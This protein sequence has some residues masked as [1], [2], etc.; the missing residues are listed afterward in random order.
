MHEHPK[1]LI[2]RQVCYMLCF[3]GDMNKCLVTQNRE[4]TIVQ[5]ADATRVKLSDLVNLLD[6]TWRSGD[7]GLLMGVDCI[8]AALPKHTLV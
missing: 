3:L 8:A 6:I 4:L 7:N 2:K 5:R 1:L